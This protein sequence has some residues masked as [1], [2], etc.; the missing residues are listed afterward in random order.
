MNPPPSAGN[1]GRS[2][3]PAL[4]GWLAACALL[5]LMQIG[6][7]PHRVYNPEPEDYLRNYPAAGEA[8]ARFDLAVIEFDDYGGLWNRDQLDGTIDLIQQRNAEAERG[9]LVS[10]FIHGWTHDADPHRPG[11]D[12][13]GFRENLAWVA[14][15]IEHGDG[16][17]PD[18]V[19]GVYIGWRGATTRFPVAKQLTFYDRRWAAERMVSHDMRETLVRI[20]AATKSRPGSKCLQTGH[21]MGGLILGQAMS[22][23]LATLLLVG[24]D[25][26]E[27]AEIDLVLLAN[28]ARDALAAK[29]LVDFLKRT[30]TR[31]ELRTP[32]GKVL[33]DRGPLIVS[34]TS[35]ADDATGLVYPLGRGLST[36]GGAFRGDHA[37]GEPSQRHL[38][39][40]TEGHV[41]F[42]ISHTAR[43][44]DDGR[45]VLEEA[46]GRYNDTPF[47]IVR[48]TKDICADHGDLD[49]PNF[50]RLVRQIIE[51][52]QLYD[53]DVR[54]WIVSDTWK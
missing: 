51:L 38:V 14:Q 33:P 45:V 11:G 49:N 17:P 12:L 10:V 31:T 21:S 1:P 32:E 13:S 28:P 43:L 50:G 35:E 9:V 40:H 7:V 15:R 4:R 3:H 39:T 53:A 6:C 54:K 16:L 34:I 44:D 52:N 24:D 22:H 48:V 41:P 2:R 46:P 47:W 5:A 19:V 25:D 8:D 20:A 30:N 18:R 27:P 23:T 26:G 37:E 36:L 29:Q 42:L